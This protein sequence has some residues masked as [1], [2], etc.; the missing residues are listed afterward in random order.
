MS[1]TY[2]IVTIGA[3][4][5]DVY[6]DQATADAYLEADSNATAWRAATDDTKGRA[7]VSATR[8]LDRQTWQGEKT[9][10]DQALEWPRSGIADVDEGSVPQKIIDAC[11]ELAAA[12]VDGYDAAN[13]RTTD[14]NIK[15]QKAGS[16]EIEYF[17]PLDP[18]TRLPLP[19]WEL[20]KAWLSGNVSIAASIATGTDGCSDFD[21]DYS[22]TRGV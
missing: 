13:N 1:A 17:R 5:Y 6:A 9:E 19:V 12:I 20:I 10:S 16:V 11:C 22:L 8:I 15:R 21:N 7:L 4:Q 3:N 14:T 18:G 2:N